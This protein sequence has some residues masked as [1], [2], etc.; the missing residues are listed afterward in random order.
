M[1][2][3]RMAGLRVKPEKVVFAT[4]EISFLGY[5]VSP[6]AVRIDPE[7]TRAIREFPTP[8]ETRVI[9]RFTGMVNIYHK[10]IPDLPTRRR[11]STP[12]VRKV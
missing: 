11:P 9:S 10:F 7:R 8:R 4:Q 1:D 3:L 2:R 12:S 6:T 5:L